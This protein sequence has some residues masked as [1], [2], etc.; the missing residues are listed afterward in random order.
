MKV[1]ALFVMPDSYYKSIQGVDAF[2]AD[3]DA[4]TFTGGL[5]VVAHPPCRAWSRMRHFAK[6]RPGERDLALFAIDMV[7]KCGGV[8]EHPSGSE[9]W[10]VAGLPAP[11]STAVDSFGGWTLPISQKWFGHRA[12]KRTWLYIVGVSPIAIPVFPLVLGEA[13][14]VCGLWSGRDRSRA[15]KKI[16]PVERMASPPAF[17]HW[18]VD[19]AVSCK[20]GS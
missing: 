17:A 13:E 12:E 8:V 10:K 14:R 4:L 11:G 7:R 5:P 9:L 2:D 16:G 6:P 20:V 3:R 18:L 1:A 15:R 19:L